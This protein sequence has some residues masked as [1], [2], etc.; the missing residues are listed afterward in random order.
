LAKVSAPYEAK[1][2]KIRESGK[3]IIVKR[4]LGYSGPNSLPKYSEK[5]K[6]DKNNQNYSHMMKGELS[7]LGIIW[8]SSLGNQSKRKKGDFV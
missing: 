8:S 4:T 3:E 2:Q 5:L 6:V 1:P 7:M